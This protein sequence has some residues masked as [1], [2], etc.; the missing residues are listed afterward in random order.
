MFIQKQCVLTYQHQ[1]TVGG[2]VRDSTPLCLFCTL[3][4]QLFS[5]SPS[6]FHLTTLQLSPPPPSLPLP[7]SHSLSPSLPPSLPPSAL[8]PSPP[9]LLLTSMMYM[10]MYEFTH[11]VNYVHDH[12]VN[13]HV[14]DKYTLYINMYI[15]LAH[16]W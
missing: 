10:Y 14:H 2:G 6:S 1:Y 3:Q 8:Y 5:W 16:G 11:Y 12:N 13:L 9:P 4:C 15:C 7:L